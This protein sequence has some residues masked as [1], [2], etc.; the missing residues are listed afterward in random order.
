MLLHRG[1][2][3]AWLRAL[4]AALCIG[5][6]AAFSAPVAAAV[7]RS[8]A[9]EAELV[10]AQSAIVPGRPLLLGLRLK[11]DPGW[12]VYWKN[13]GD[14]GTAPTLKL[15]VP[16]GLTP[17]AMQFAL[18]QRIPIAHLVNF[19]Y[20]GEV[21]F[22]LEVDVPQSFSSAGPVTIAARA[23]WLECKESCLPASAQL[24][25]TLAVAATSVP[26]RWSSLF[27]RTALRL[28]QRLPEAVKLAGTRE[29]GRA[30]LRV[31][32]LTDCP[33][34]EF[35]PEREGVFVHA[36]IARDRAAEDLRFSLPF[37]T[38]ATAPHDLT[39]VLTCAHADGARRAFAISTPLAVGSPALP[40]GQA[41]TTAA[42]SLAAALLSAFIGG[43]V[44]NAMP[45][46][47]PVLGLKVL[48]L[49][50]QGGALDDRRVG[51]ATRFAL[52]VVASCLLLAFVM[53]ALRAG[54]E[55]VGWGF[56]LQSSGFVS[57]LAVLFFV[58]ALNLSGTFQWGFG[59]QSVAGRAAARWSGP[60]LDGVLLVLV[61]SPCTAPLMGAAIGYTLSKPPA[62]VIAVFAALAIGIAAP[63][64]LLLVCPGLLRRMPKPGPWL[65][66]ARQ[67]LAFPLYA[68]VLWLAWVLGELAGL[69]AAIRLACLLLAL[70]FAIWLWQRRGRR[71]IAF[72]IAGAIVAGAASWLVAG[73]EPTA[74]KPTPGA[75]EWKA[76]SAAAQADY[77]AQGRSVLVDFTAAWCITCQVNK[78][79]VLNTGAVRDALRA[80]GV[81]AL[82]ADWTRR[83]P[84]I[85]R[86]LAALGRNGVPVYALY[87]ADGRVTLLPE[88]LTTQ[89]VVAALRN[90]TKVAGDL[91]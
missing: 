16:A 71:L 75:D 45:C 66:T 9:A 64:A 27:E 89:L 56:Q 47:F 58:L 61:A 87:A 62:T 46:V 12:H 79:T 37:E 81:V 30:D 20:E 34:A 23:D 8:T 11:L 38:N 31:E 63:Y 13:A 41:S 73:L 72:S 84:E 10:A 78:V 19:G 42:L 67:F 43:L 76:W 28:P 74:A 70:V 83:D 35:F 48:G 85:A 29:T 39:G 26:S 1:Q 14:S 49:S 88:I 55:Q 5:S 77:R 69:G 54:G 82:R 33:G 22:P 18:P 80:S 52:G 90:H 6:L 65:E 21:L 68:T 36:Q 4:L 25:V 32:G 91:R 59:I 44:L 7:V 3:M 53:L 2:E 86:A 57:A 51:H 15:D 17:G 60:F 24:A 50:R 40:G